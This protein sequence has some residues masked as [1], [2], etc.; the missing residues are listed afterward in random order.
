MT[1]AL[2]YLKKLIVP[3]HTWSVR[4]QAAALSE[5]GLNVKWEPEPLVKMG[6]FFLSLSSGTTAL[7]IQ[8]QA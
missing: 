7:C 1:R 5:G 6:P 4:S 2:I 3:Y 8:E